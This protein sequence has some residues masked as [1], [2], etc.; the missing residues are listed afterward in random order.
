MESVLELV[1]PLVGDKP[2]ELINEVPVSLPRVVADPNRLQ[3]ILL[4]LIGNAVKFT[5]S[6]TV[7]VRAEDVNGRIEIHVRDTGIGID[8][9]M[10]MQYF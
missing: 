4:N 10:W 6:G 8:Q 7:R 9:K 3:Q 5:T 2:L 1:H